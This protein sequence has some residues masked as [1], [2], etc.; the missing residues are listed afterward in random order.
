MPS[1]NFKVIKA[2]AGTGK[3][4]NLVKEY[5]QLALKNGAP[6]Y[7]KHILAI[8]FTNAA[9]AE[10]K[11]RVLKNLK[12][13]AD[14]SY[15]GELLKD[16]ANH[17][18]LSEQEVKDRA[19]EVF[20][21]MLHNYGQLSILTID[22]FTSKLIRSF[23][24]DLHLKYDF[25]IEINSTAFMEKVV[26]ECISLIGEDE[27]LTNWLIGYALRNA[28][29][30]A[31]WNFRENILSIA[32]EMLK[33]TA[34]PALK[35]LKDLSYD[36]F[37]N[38]ASELQKKIVSFENHAIKL[39]QQGLDILNKNGLKPENFS[40]GKSGG[41]MF[42]YKVG[43][44]RLMVPPASRTLGYLE[45]DD[46]WVAKKVSPEL[47]QAV[48]EIQP[49]MKALLNDLISH[50][51]AEALMKYGLQKTIHKSIYTIGL[52]NKLQ[53]IGEKIRDEENLLLISDFHRMVN[54]VVRENN[55]PF[56][57]ERIGV[58]YRHIMIDEFQDTS[59]LQWEN[60]L[61]LIDNALA[62][63]H[64]NLIVGDAKQAI[65]RWRGGDARQFVILPQI[66][67]ESH[68]PITSL[69][70]HYE[71]KILQ[72]SFRSASSIVEFNNQLYLG[73]TAEDETLR[74]VYHE[75]QQLTKSKKEG[76][77]R[78]TF[79]D[80]KNKSEKRPEAL[81][82]ILLF[83]QESIED[84][85]QPGDIAI[86]TRK[87]KKDTA[88]IVTML[89]ENG[90][91]VVTKESLLADYSP[92]V[93][94]VLSYLNY[95]FVPSNKFAPASLIQ[96][97]TS[98]HTQISLSHFYLNYVSCAGKSIK[99]AYDKFIED[100]FACEDQVTLTTSPVE[101]IL[102]SVRKFRLEPDS[103]LELLLEKVRAMCIEGHQSMTEFL[104]WWEDN[105]ENLS[106]SSVGSK[107][108]IQIMTIHKSKGL[109][110]PVVIYPRLSG[111][112]QSDKIWIDLDEKEYGLPAALV[113]SKSKESNESFPP[114]Y[115]LE[116]KAQLIDEINI[117]YVA[118]TRPKDRLYMIIENDT[119]NIL[120]K[121][122]IE[123]IRRLNPENQQPELVMGSREKNQNSPSSD[124]ASL[125]PFDAAQPHSWKIRS[126]TT[127]DHE[128][129]IYGELLHAC[130]HQVKTTTDISSA[131]VATTKESANHTYETQ[132]TADLNKI[133]QHPM[134]EPWFNGSGKILR[135][136]EIV[137]MNGTVIRPDRVVVFDDHV[138]VIDY[139]SGSKSERHID[140]VKS[141]MN[142]IASI[143]GLKVN[144]FILYTR[145]GEIDVVA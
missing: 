120:T 9:A 100:H 47:K 63:N 39:A 75:H 34:I 60:A 3:T 62:E 140:Q 70:H 19:N 141:Y 64:L 97:L 24:K 29:E 27:E 71:E 20:Q 143:E 33:E 81:K 85:Y 40:Y 74:Q 127:L 112:I 89:L 72:T 38:I 108:A 79:H 102:M 96:A 139:K 12:S 111:K 122:I 68:L 134:A 2:S 14:G 135:E 49:Q 83:V 105:R 137:T 65:Y 129:V 31:N 56:I 125:I 46:D 117:C 6:W 26:D 57:F 126:Q 7:Y 25:R 5:I 1:G 128:A 119:K 116:Y 92:V 98:I 37:I 86:L 55:A 94:A 69:H 35:K 104:Q 32:K 45:K 17:L 118:T 78:I 95:L 113:N 15:Q 138:D 52:I 11:E 80:G 136:Q 144:G 101:A 8:T 23:S 130:L 51:S 61:P 142:E 106:T 54:D 82:D 99:F 76:L 28:E 103:G 44:R 59:V 36:D 58:R 121:Q 115:N 109:E 107:D 30:E 67:P 124:M 4:Y 114:E 90:Y 93:R 53:Q 43:T 22:S 16:I 13:F 10:M 88:V 73:L 48:A 87:G 66:S 18:F 41:M 132:L 133:I 42:L 123:E 110:F 145:T 50:M 77:V 21:H 91:Q 131:I 84:G